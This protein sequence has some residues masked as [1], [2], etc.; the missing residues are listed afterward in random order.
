M[1]TC[2]AV[3][4][5]AKQNATFATKNMWKISVRHHRKETCTFRNSFSVL[6]QKSSSISLYKIRHSNDHIPYLLMITKK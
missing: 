2:I 6:W 5:T 4:H 3:V 1:Y